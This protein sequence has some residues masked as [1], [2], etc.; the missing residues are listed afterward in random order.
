MME[1]WN[2]GFNENWPIYKKCRF[3]GYHDR[4]SL[5]V[6]KNC[7]VSHGFYPDLRTLFFGLC[8]IVLFLVFVGESVAEHNDLI[9]KYETGDKKFKR[10]EIGNT[11]SYFHQRIIDGAV[12]ENDFIVYQFDRR[13][14]ELI[15]KKMHWRTDLPEQIATKITQKHAESMVKGEVQS[16]KLYIIS[17]ESH[18]FPLDPTPEN[19][20]WVVRSIT[21]GNMI[22]T[23]IDAV[24]GKIAGY[25]VPPPK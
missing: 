16:A 11:I 4:K 21:D 7:S 18:V 8:L 24:T 23:I 17:P 13:T 6:D 22:V 5:F 20:C 19:P 25:G 10:F 15:D 14:K 2:N 1:F 3:M 12:V 9:K